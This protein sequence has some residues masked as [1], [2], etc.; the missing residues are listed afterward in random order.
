MFQ[1]HIINFQRLLTTRLFLAITCSFGRRFS[2]L[3]YSERNCTKSVVS[4]QYC[5]AIGFGFVILLCIIKMCFVESNYDLFVVTFSSTI[6]GFDEVVE[7]LFLFRSL[8]FKSYLFFCFFNK[9][10]KFIFL[11]F[12]MF[13]IPS[14]LAFFLNSSTVT[15]V[16][17]IFSRFK[18]LSF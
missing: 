10:N 7:S 5:K 17:F 18:L 1:Y 16:V 9:S 13:L 4:F 8:T 11:I 3:T 14:L 15:I 12:L 6:V 2:L